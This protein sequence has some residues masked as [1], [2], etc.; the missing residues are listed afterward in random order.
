MHVNNLNGNN[1]F[2]W[3]W[4]N[5]WIMEFIDNN[6]CCLAAFGGLRSGKKKQSDFDVFIYQP[7]TQKVLE[8]N[9][10]A[11]LMKACAPCFNST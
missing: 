5:T 1:S 2:W 10:E 11:N 7:S 9:T 4:T 3:T 8:N 6:Y